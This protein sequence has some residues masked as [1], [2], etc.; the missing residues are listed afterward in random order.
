M[1][2]ITVICEGYTEANYIS[3][4]NDYVWA[5]SQEINL[6]E[7]NLKGINRNN[8]ISKIRKSLNTLAVP[9]ITTYIFL[10]KDI[11][12]RAGDN[13]N[14]VVAEIESVAN[15]VIAK[16]K[17]KATIVGVIKVIFNTMNGE[18][19][20][21]LHENENIAKQ[22]H[23]IMKT[24]N[25]FTSPLVAKDYEPLVKSINSQYKKNQKIVLNK[26]KLQQFVDNNKN[27]E[28][29]MQSDIAKL[30]QIVIEQEQ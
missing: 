5:I 7:R 6:D 28:I 13:I 20:M 12:I 21:M 15:Q 8:Y 19:M 9:N 18:D 16:S 17:K 23:E 30:V 27:K 10:D 14:D 22:W 2:N 25:H 26:Y 29:S 3:A 4:L 24:K 1:K 11:F